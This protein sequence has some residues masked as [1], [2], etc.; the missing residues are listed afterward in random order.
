[1]DLTPPANTKTILDLW[2]IRS[3]GSDVWSPLVP[4]NP[5]RGL[6]SLACVGGGSTSHTLL[7][8]CWGRARRMY[9][10]AAVGLENATQSLRGGNGPFTGLLLM[11]G[12]CFWPAL[13]KGVAANSSDV[14]INISHV[15][16]DHPAAPVQNYLQFVYG[17]YKLP[18]DKITRQVATQ[19]IEARPVT[20]EPLVVCG[21]RRDG[22]EDKLN[23]YATKHCE[24][25][26]QKLQRASHK[27]ASARLANTIK[28]FMTVARIKDRSGAAP[29]ILR[30]RVAPT[31][32]VAQDNMGRMV[33]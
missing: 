25:Y 10:T 24:K 2:K 15:D 16:V 33:T 28:T 20:A 13:N 23:K 31:T 14:Y 11:P 8:L 7:Y 30:G 1:M 6:G 21:D 3:F 22:K 18:L 32:K 5:M 12:V 17:R 29:A 9:Y 27:C 19:R 26:M 4:R